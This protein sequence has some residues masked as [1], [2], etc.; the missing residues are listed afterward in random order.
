[1]SYTV[2]DPT[3]PILRVVDD[4]TLA[5]YSVEEAE[6]ID[7]KSF[8]TTWRTTAAGESITLPFVPGQTYDLVAYWGDGSSDAITAWDQAEA[9]HAYADAGD[10]RIIIAGSMGGWSVNIGPDKDKILTVD[11][12]GSVG[13]V[14]LVGGF[15]KCLLLSSVAS[16]TLPGVSALTNAFNDGRGIV[17]LGSI[18]T[19]NCTNFVGAYRDQH[20]KTTIAVIDVYA[21]T[22]FN[23]CWISNRLIESFPALA[24]G[25]DA[26]DFTDTWNSCRELK[27]FPPKMFDIVVSNKFSG[28]FDHCKLTDESVDNI[29]ISIDVA[30]QINGTLDIGGATNE[31]PSAAGWAAYDSLVAKGWTVTVNGTHP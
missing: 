30:G 19:P 24:F 27:H 11:Q 26:F 3:Q 7:G 29:L 18:L 31:P 9:T 28:A 22:V 6:L 25:P 2:A 5:S 23:G 1:M 21:G 8:I 20:I 17:D 14:Y 13:L 16:G 4:A 12:W 10:H 15:F